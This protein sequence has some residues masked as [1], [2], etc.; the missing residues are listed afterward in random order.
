LQN[1]GLFTLIRLFVSSH[2]TI[3]AEN[4]FLRKQ[5]ALL[6]ERRVKPQRFDTRRYGSAVAVLRMA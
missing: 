1:V 4:R 3:V 6:Q 2:A 5:L